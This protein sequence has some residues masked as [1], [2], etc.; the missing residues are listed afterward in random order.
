MLKIYKSQSTTSQF[1]V[2]SEIYY[3]EGWKAYIDGKETP[4]LRANYI[5]RAVEVPAG[6]H[7]IELRCEPD[8]L[9]TF[10]IINLIGSIIIIA[11]ILG[12]IALPIIKR[13]KEKK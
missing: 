10:N 3:A 5:L 6:E 8:T 7:T 9:K 12:A 13:F 2:F 4:L 1:C 11:F